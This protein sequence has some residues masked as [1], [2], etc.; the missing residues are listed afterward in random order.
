MQ[1]NPFMYEEFIGRGAYFSAL[2][3][4]RTWS[5]SIGDVFLW[6]CMGVKML[7]SSLP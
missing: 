3:D 4:S 1:G 7:S 5:Q 6:D 2:A